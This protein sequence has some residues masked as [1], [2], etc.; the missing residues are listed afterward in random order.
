[1][2]LNV[3]CVRDVLLTLE[4]EQYMNDELKLQILYPDSLL[5]YEKCK[6][7]NKDEITYTILKLKEAGFIDAN[8][9]SNNNEILNVK[10]FDITYCGH[11]YLETIRDNKVWSQTKSIAEKIGCKSLD[12]LIEIASRVI[13][14][15]ITQQF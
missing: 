3:D 2:T 1:M 4:E 10:I 13:T 14:N 15:L 9:L 7:Y 5:E 11:Q 12:V 6:K 8:I